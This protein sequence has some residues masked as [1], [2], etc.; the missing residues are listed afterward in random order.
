MYFNIFPFFTDDIPISGKEFFCRE[1]ILPWCKVYNILCYH[2]MCLYCKR[3][4]E[5]WKNS[6]S[7]ICT[8]CLP[9]EFTS[10]DVGSAGITSER[11]GVLE[12]LRK[13]FNTVIIN[14]SKYLLC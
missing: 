9:V 3:L 14:L 8:T 2:C 13:N 5:K 4:P 6:N 7:K 11:C 10:T 12:E 1:H